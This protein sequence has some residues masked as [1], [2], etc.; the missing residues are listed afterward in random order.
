M[1]AA[2][3]RIS[4][5][6]AMQIANKITA[7]LAPACERIVVAGSCRRRVREVADI[8]VVAI[9]ARS[10]DLLGGA[11]DNRLLECLRQLESTPALRRVRGGERARHYLV[12]STGRGDQY[13]LGLEVY[14]CEVS[15]WPVVLALRTGPRLFSQALVTQVQH[16]GRLPDGYCVSDGRVRQLGGAGEVCQ[17]NSER[18]FLQF[19]GG[20]VDPEDRG[21]ALIDGPDPERAGRSAGPAQ[22][23]AVARSGVR[24][25][26]VESLEQCGPATCDELEVRLDRPHQTVSGALR[27]LEDVGLV[28][29]TDARRKTRRGFSAHVYESE[30][31]AVRRVAW[32]R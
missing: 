9:P 24:A 22:M 5:R 15:T 1:S 2:Q 3:R 21:A 29:K 28:R 32:A 6:Q 20:W 8:D 10:P 4:L 31:N 27:Y 11:G 30:G 14:M 23:V 26:I 13:D 19:A 25:S 16:G 7:V 12:R 18:E 17:F